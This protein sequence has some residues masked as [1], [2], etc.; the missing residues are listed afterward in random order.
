MQPLVS[1]ARVFLTPHATSCE[2]A[3]E[4]VI[5]DAASGQY[6]A[7]NPVGTAVWKHL[8]QPCT[9]SALCHRLQD[10]YDVT[11]DRCQ[12]DVSNLLREL[13][14]RGLVRLEM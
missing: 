10:E 6:F 4:T 7:L 5:L 3:G 1:S 9:V 13:A 2:I 11:D 12:T 14:E 8:Q